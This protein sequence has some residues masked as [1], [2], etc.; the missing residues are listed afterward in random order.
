MT[1]R[2]MTALLVMLAAA[3]A[4]TAVAGAKTLVLR[5]AGGG[6]LGPGSELTALGPMTAQGGEYT[7]QCTEEELTGSISSKR[8]GAVTV[9]LA[10]YRFS[11]CT[12]SGGLASE[13]FGISVRPGQT[14]WTLSFAAR[15][16]AHLKGSKHIEY[17]A[18]GSNG[19]FGFS[20]SY[21]GN[22]FKG[23]TEIEEG[24]GYVFVSFSGEQL[25]SAKSN[26]GTCPAIGSTSS[27]FQLFS[28]GEPVEATR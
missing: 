8:E 6:E 18:E 10:G 23:T 14:P 21:E 19:A 5:T 11:G 13:P 20:C 4:F 3:L 26:D 2:T 12:L 7:V 27:H 24:S 9:P 25:H 16:S 28:E 15:G 22:T 1:K 17:T